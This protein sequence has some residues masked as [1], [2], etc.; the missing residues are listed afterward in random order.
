MSAEHAEAIAQFLQGKEPMRVGEIAQSDDCPVPVPQQDPRRSRRNDIARHVDA[1]TQA[2]NKAVR[3][4]L[5]ERY[6]LGSHAGDR[7]MFGGVGPYYYRVVD[8]HA[9]S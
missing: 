6:Q 4:G 1:I 5:V 8:D 3:L 7:I 9:V 2:L